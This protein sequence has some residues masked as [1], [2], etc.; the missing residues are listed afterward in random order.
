[1]DKKFAAAPF[2]IELML[3]GLVAKGRQSAFVSWLRHLAAA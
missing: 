2:V 3:K 1:M